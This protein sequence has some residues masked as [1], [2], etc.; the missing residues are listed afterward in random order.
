MV[1][2][3]VHFQ[4]QGDAVSVGQ[5][6]LENYLQGVASET[7]IQGPQD[8]TTIDSLKVA[9]SEIRLTPVE[10]LALHQA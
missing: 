10:I 5:A 8:S 1:Y 2:P 6:S 3:D 4:P 7:M 9:L